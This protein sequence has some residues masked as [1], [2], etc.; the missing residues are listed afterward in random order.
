[1]TG[2]SQQI[3]PPSPCKELTI[4]GL[5]LAELLRTAASLLEQQ[6]QQVAKSK[7]FFPTNDYRRIYIEIE[8]QRMVGRAF[9]APYKTYAELAELLTVEVGWFVDELNLRQNFCRYTKTQSLKA[10][11]LR[12]AAQIG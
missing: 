1:M 8:A 11:I 7:P 6:T 12:R 3:T 10:D 4:S 9:P 5:Q 2:I